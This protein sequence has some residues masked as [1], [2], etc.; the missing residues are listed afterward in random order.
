V[1]ARLV[2]A[3]FVLLAVAGGQAAAQTGKRYGYEPG[4]QHYLQ[5]QLDWQR[6]EN[7]QQ[8][9]E[10]LR[11]QGR[12]HQQQWQQRQKLRQWQEQQRSPLQQLQRP[13]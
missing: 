4:R 6:R 5:R 1:K 3:A 2:V 7:W 11:E 13:D 8:N 10:R 9:Q 12:Q